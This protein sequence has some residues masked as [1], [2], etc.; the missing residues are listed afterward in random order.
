MNP[1][2]DKCHDFR[3][4]SSFCWVSITSSYHSLVTNPYFPILNIADR[5]AEGGKRDVLIKLLNFF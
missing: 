4:D 2:I 3:A 5:I 1:A